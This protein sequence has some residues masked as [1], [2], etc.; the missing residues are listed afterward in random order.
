MSGQSALA[1]RVVDRL[2][3]QLSV[4]KSVDV[5]LPAEIRQ[6]TNK[7]AE[8]LG[9][10]HLKLDVENR[11]QGGTRC[12][13]AFVFVEIAF[14]CFFFAMPAKT[15]RVIIMICILQLS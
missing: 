4:F 11:W 1:A 9:K 7:L 14:R 8:S 5:A 10:I 6:E 2:Q 3:K 13:Q 12:I 15:S